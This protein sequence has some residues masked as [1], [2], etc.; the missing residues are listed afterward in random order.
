MP[1]LRWSFV[2]C[3]GGVRHVTTHGQ[4]GDG[5][6]EALAAFV[7]ANARHD[8]VDDTIRKVD[9]FC[10]GQSFMMYLGTRRGRS[11]MRRS[12]ARSPCAYSS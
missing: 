3:I 11:W 12:G 5:R 2:R 4:V 9:E 6:E 1:F 7:L 10:Y 8:D